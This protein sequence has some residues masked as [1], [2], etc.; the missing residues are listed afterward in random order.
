VLYRRERTKALAR[1]QEAVSASR[2]TEPSGFS[3]AC[4]TTRGVIIEYSSNTTNH[5]LTLLVGQIYQKL[6][7]LHVITPD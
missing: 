7:I 6:F 4:R 5:F 1:G 2:P 3:S